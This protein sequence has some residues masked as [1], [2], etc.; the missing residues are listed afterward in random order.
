MTYETEAYRRPHRR[1][2][3]HLVDT[4]REGTYWHSP[5]GIVV[6]MAS[7]ERDFRGAC[8]WRRRRNGERS[9]ILPPTKSSTGQHGREAAISSAVRG[10]PNRGCGIAAAPTTPCVGAVSSRGRPGEATRRGAVATPC[11]GRRRIGG[12]PR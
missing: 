8:A 3:F 4:T 12:L 5:D 6:R 11:P 10:T 7:A 9:V 2:D 1:G